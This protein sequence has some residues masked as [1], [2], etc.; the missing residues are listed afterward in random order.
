MQL[1]E[2]DDM[3]VHI[4][5]GGHDVA[6]HLSI[7]RDND[8][9][10]VLYRPYG[11]KRMDGGT[12]SAY[13]SDENPGITRVTVFHD[14]FDSAYHRAGAICVFNLSILYIGLDPEVPFYAGKRVYYYSF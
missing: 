7:G 14:R 12:H 10:R 2:M 11:A 13:T 5:Y 8:I 9:E 3:I 1:V 4:Q 6:Y